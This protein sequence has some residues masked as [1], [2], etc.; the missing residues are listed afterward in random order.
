[1]SAGVHGVGGNQRGVF[2]I[3][4]TQQWHHVCSD[5]QKAA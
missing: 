5:A 3:V 1:M 4:R 2:I